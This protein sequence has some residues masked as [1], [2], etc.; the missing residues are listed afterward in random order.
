MK[1]MTMKL[2]ML[3]VCLSTVIRHITYITYVEPFIVDVTDEL[4]DTTFNDSYASI[5]NRDIMD[6]DVLL[7]TFYVKILCKSYEHARAWGKPEYHLVRLNGHIENASRPGVDKY[8]L[9]KISCKVC[10]IFHN[11]HLHISKCY[12]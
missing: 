10:I 1:P 6:E 2:K 9:W 8:P 4:E 11:I 7:D 12:M 3:K 5:H